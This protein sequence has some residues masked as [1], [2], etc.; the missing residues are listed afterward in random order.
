MATL[1]REREMDG[2]VIQEDGKVIHNAFQQD[3]PVIVRDYSDG[4]RHLLSKRTGKLIIAP[5]NPQTAERAHCPHCG[6]ELGGGS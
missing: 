1:V 4:M 6:G 5:F 2:A 3:D